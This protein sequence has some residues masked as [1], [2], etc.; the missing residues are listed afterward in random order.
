MGTYA[1]CFFLSQLFLLFA[2]KVWQEKHSFNDTLLKNV[3]SSECANSEIFVWK[4]LFFFYMK[5]S[6]VCHLKWEC[7][8]VCLR[9][10]CNLGAI[11]TQLEIR[12]KDNFSSIY[13]IKD[14][15]L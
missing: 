2:L 5:D 1:Y 7:F 4:D 12:T 10:G 8:S 14:K 9:E 6:K 13:C 3:Q 11:G 15:I